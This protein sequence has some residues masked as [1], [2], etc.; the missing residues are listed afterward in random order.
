[1]ERGWDAFC[2]RSA[3]VDFV[4]GWGGCEAMTNVEAVDYSD[5]FSRCD[6]KSPMQSRGT[7]EGFYFKEGVW[8]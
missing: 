7:S 3:Y 8:K 2:A 4:I 6:S 1:M 5:S